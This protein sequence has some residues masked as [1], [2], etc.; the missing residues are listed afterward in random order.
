MRHADD[1]GFLD[2][3]VLEEHRFDI[4]GVDVVAAADDHVLHAT[5]DVDEA[6]VVEV[7]EVAGAQPA[8]LGPRARGG[9]VVVVVLAPL[10]GQPYEQLADFVRAASRRRSRDRR[11]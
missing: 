3:G 9:A 8:V 6:V 4:G 5:R 10:A 7:R 11:P 1:R 2:V